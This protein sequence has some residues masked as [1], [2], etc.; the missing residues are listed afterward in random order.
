V[1]LVQDGAD[2]DCKRVPNSDDGSHDISR[3][4]RCALKFLS[5]MLQ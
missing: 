3:D 5:L 4:P 2:E 1:F